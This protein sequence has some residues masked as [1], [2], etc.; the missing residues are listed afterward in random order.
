MRGWRIRALGPGAYTDPD[1]NVYDK[2]GDMQLEFNAEYRFPIY[3]FFEGGLFV[4]AGNIWLLEQS[5][6]YP[7]AH[8]E[9]GNFLEQLALDAGFGLRLDF[10]FFT[11]RLD[12]AVPMRQPSEPLGKRWQSPFEI[13]FRDMVLNF[14][15][16]YPF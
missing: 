3:R 1:E 2:I 11:L 14:G 13:E 15:I 12:A 5:E 7:K 10:N 16:G 6:D 9:F 4:D 8:F